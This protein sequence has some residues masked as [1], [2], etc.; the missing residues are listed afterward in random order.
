MTDG[1]EA[2]LHPKRVAALPAS[3][4]PPPAKKKK[5]QATS[6][7]LIR[8]EILDV[9]SAYDALL[10]SPTD[11]EPY[12]QTLVSAGASELKGVA[13]LGGCPSPWRH[14]QNP[15][16]RD[17]SLPIINFPPH[18]NTH[19]LE[20]QP[21]RRPPDAWPPACCP[22]SPRSAPASASPPARRCW[23]WRR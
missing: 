1:T 12:V 16:P 7:D 21:G 15:C 17:H 2:S 22:A 13:A 8:R 18:P 5:R 10:S 9:Y 20:S 4:A 19:L 11:P 14:P 3:A 6:P 23:S